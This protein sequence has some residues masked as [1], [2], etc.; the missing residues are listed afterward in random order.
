MRAAP[1]RAEPASG[2]ADTA[3]PSSL[4]IRGEGRREIYG[5]LL[6]ESTGREVF[7][8]HEDLIWPEMIVCGHADR[9][10]LRAVGR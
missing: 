4:V 3:Q 7:E 8:S 2:C 1:S 6:R 10:E 5:L 9:D